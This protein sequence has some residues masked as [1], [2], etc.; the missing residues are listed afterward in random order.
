VKF[1]V[2]TSWCSHTLA[3]FV[4]HSALYADL[5]THITAKNYDLLPKNGTAEGYLRGLTKRRRADGPNDVSVWP[6][7]PSSGPSAQTTGL[8]TWGRYPNGHCWF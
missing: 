1:Q 4:T 6:D 7:H 8:A 3:L 2:V 5:Q